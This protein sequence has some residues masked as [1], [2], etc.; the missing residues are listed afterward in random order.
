MKIEN[1]TFRVN[2]HSAA[3]EVFITNPKGVNTV[4]YLPP[5]AEVDPTKPL[6]FIPA[7]PPVTETKTEPSK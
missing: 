5:D 7:P 6:E 4:I 2:K 3:T 1:C